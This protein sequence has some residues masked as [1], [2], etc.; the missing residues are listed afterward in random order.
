[1]GRDYAAFAGRPVRAFTQGPEVGDAIIAIH[2]EPGNQ[3][4]HAGSSCYD[5]MIPHLFR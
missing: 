1:V 2:A 5:T 4:K 3:A